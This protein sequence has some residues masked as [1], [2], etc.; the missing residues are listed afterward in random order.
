[1]PIAVLRL[2]LTQ[3]ITVA[4][5]ETIT[6]PSNVGEAT[7]AR[8]SLAK[9]LYNKLF[10]WI[11][12]KINAVLQP[13]A[14]GTSEGGEGEGGRDEQLCVGVLDVYGFEVFD[15]NSFEQLCINFWNE[16]MQQCVGDLPPTPLIIS[17]PGS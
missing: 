13:P 10:R 17:S 15:T 5:G 6:K 16:H 3:T 7:T 2:A 12:D 9:A 1:M 8:N 14:S 4:R 11:R